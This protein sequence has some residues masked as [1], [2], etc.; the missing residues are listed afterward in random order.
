[1]SG[2]KNS[3]ITNVA[4][5]KEL[6]VFFWRS[7]IWW[8]TPVVLALVLLSAIVVLTESS[9]LAPFIYTLF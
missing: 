6:L 8:L 7:K 4:T 5:V 1:M 9:A 3:L 2:N